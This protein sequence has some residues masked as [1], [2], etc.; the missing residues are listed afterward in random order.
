MST[1]HLEPRPR[2]WRAGRTLMLLVTVTSFSAAEPHNAIAGA[3]YTLEASNLQAL[4]EVGAGG[5]LLQATLDMTG[6]AQSGEVRLQPGTLA[7]YATRV[8]GLHADGFE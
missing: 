5:Y 2:R 7:V 4:P 3:G 8:D 1:R 6:T